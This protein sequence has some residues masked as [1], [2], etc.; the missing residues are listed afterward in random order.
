MVCPCYIEISLI[1]FLDPLYLVYKSKL[2]QKCKNINSKSPPNSGNFD[3]ILPST[4]WSFSQVCLASPLVSLPLFLSKAVLS[5]LILWESQNVHSQLLN[6]NFLPITLSC[7]NYCDTLYLKVYFI[8]GTLPV[9]RYGAVVEFFLVSFAS[10]SRCYPPYFG[11]TQKFSHF[12][13]MTP[14]LILFI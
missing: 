14:P 3:N 4:A 8:F 2:R 10:L 9:S 13:I 1:P 12:L 11:K 5:F 6:T 7:V